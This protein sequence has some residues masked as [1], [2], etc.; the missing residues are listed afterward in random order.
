MNQL[1]IYTVD[2]N[3]HVTHVSEIN[4]QEFIDNLDEDTSPNFIEVFSEDSQS[5]FSVNRAKV[6]AYEYK[7][8]VEVCVDDEDD[9]EIY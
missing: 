5:V 1:K 7:I 2:G 6:E 8:E 3:T 4:L 9:Y